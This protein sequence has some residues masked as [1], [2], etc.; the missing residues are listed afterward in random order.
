MIRYTGSGENDT[1]VGTIG[2]IKTVLRFQYINNHIILLY[3]LYINNHI[4]L[5]YFLFLTVPL[6]QLV[7][8]VELAVHA[9]AA[10]VVLLCSANH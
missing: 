1:S 8:T 2:K 9:G 10:K 7:L 4:A 5:L 6:A 3:L